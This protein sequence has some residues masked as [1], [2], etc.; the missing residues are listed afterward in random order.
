MTIN[1][2]KQNHIL[3]VIKKVQIS[4]LFCVKF[5]LF[6]YQSVQ[7][8]VLDAPIYA[9]FPKKMNDALILRPVFV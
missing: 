8:C 4:E 6:F 1:L 2:S 5:G 3:M 7:T 9:L